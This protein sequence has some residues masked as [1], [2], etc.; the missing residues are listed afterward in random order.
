MSGLVYFLLGERTKLVKIGWCRRFLVRRV[1][2]LQTGSPD[3]LILLGILKGGK[4][5]E[6]DLHRRFNENRKYL[7]WFDFSEDINKLIASECLILNISVLKAES[8]DSPTS[9]IALVVDHYLSDK[10]TE[11]DFNQIGLTEY[12]VRQL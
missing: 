10:V 5:L 6:A 2:Q 4:S 11:C 1:N 12:L 9:P 3:K 7:E 8:S